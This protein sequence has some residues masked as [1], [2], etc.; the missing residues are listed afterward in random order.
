MKNRKIKTHLQTITSQ[1]IL[2]IN[3]IIFIKASLFSVFKN[4]HAQLFIWCHI[5][6]THRIIKF[7]NYQGKTWYCSI[8]VPHCFS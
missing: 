8:V 6:H 7:L 4:L 5:P 1:N 3:A 2:F